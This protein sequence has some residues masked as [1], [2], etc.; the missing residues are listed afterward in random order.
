MSQASYE[1]IYGQLPQANTYLVSLRDTSAT[2]IERQAGLLMNQAAVSSVVQNASAIRLFDSVASSLNQTMT[3][4]VIVSV[5][6]AIVILYNLT[7]INVAERIRELSTI[8]VLGFHNNEV[9]L[10]IYR[11][12]IVLS[13]VGIVLGLV[14]GFYLHQ[15]LIQ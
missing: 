5:L 6:L 2:S 8:K 3:I 1:Q 15:F 12:T 7:N 10:Y 4:L 9:T 13:L 14:S 11:E